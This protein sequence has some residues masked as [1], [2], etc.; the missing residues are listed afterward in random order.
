MSGPFQKT[1]TVVNER[2]IHNRPSV[3]LAKKAAEFDATIK[4]RNG[5]KVADASS[6]MQVMILAATCG[7]E[8]EVTAEGPDGEKAIEEIS[9]LI[10]SHFEKAYE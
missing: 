1:A 2:G 10:E 3:V 7:T 9:A 8:L 6:V 4:L 5:E